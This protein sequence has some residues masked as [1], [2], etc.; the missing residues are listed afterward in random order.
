MLVT[1]RVSDCA[2]TTFF[3]ITRSAASRL[4]PFEAFSVSGGL[5]NSFSPQGA[6]G[7]GSVS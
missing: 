5:Q 6:G 4:G 7:G 1:L 3:N 2:T